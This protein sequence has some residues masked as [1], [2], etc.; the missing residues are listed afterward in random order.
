MM[1]TPR[2]NPSHHPIMQKESPIVQTICHLWY[3]ADLSNTHGRRVQR[4]LM[5]LS[6]TMVLVGTAWGVFFYSL[7]NWPV[8][9]LDMLLVVGG[10]ATA[11]FIWR[12]KPEL[13]AAISFV[14]LFVV[15]C[16]IA[17]AFDSATPQ[18]PRTTQLYL[19]PLS[20]AAMLAFRTS[21][22]WLKFGAPG[23]CLVALAL[24]SLGYGS[25]FPQYALP[26]SIKASG[27][28]VQ[29]VT[30]LSLFFVILHVM[31]HDAVVRSALENELLR[32][33]ECSELRLFYQP[34][35]DSLGRVIGAEALLRWEHPERGLITPGEFLETAEQSGLILPIGKWVALMA[36]EQ[37]KL[38]SKK[39]NFEHLRI[40]INISQLQLRQND[41]VPHIQSLIEQFHIQANQLELEITESMLVDDIQDV[42]KK[43]NALHQCGVT[44]S[45]FHWMILEPATRR[46]TT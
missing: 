36:C 41:F 22:P 35:V 26:E 37:L 40:A 45:L 4:A 30:A 25:P 10:L 16:A 38:W 15:I 12:Q 1:K 9:G 31:Q 24:L 44:F 32:A 33:I 43:M 21:M 6:A 28:I 27:A 34:Q 18:A 11:G 39:A 20:V 19:M 5:L 14:T 23:I 8:V 7:G 46:S 17:W 3:G 2:I 42:V 13:A 29:T